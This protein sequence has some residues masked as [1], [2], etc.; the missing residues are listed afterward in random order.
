MTELPPTPL[1]QPALHESGLRH[2][3]GQARY[4][5]DLPAPLVAHVLTSPLPRGRIVRLDVTAARAV[6]GV[7]A[8]L[9]ARD[10]P[11]KNDI[12]PIFHDEPLL[13]E[14]EVFAV[15]QAIVLVVGD[16][17]AACRAGA[18]AVVLELES[19]S[20]Q[21]PSEVQAKVAEVLGLGRHKVTV[22]VP[23]WAAAS[24]ARRPRARTTPPWRRWR[25]ARHG[26]PVKVWLNR[27][28]DMQ[29]TGK[30]HPFLARYEAGFDATGQLLGAARGE[31]RR[32]RLEPRP[33][34]RHPRCAPVPP[35]QRLLTCR[36]A[37]VGR[38]AKTARPPRP[39]PRF[40]AS[41]ARRACGHRG[42]H[43]SRAAELDLPA[44]GA[45]AQLLR[46]GPARRD[47]VPP[48]R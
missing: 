10:I 37:L 45:R 36:R 15:G 21:H 41:A 29:L 32:R 2:T 31:L 24:A 22:E 26:R 4:V 16:S 13:A 38:I 48:G 1:Y 27:D 44:R 33:V 12:A 42:H 7:R 8:V 47:A 18:R 46:R 6:P 40:A 23:R 35:R 43:G 3:T 30:R 9:T 39:T 25:R 17:Y 14:S 11:G 28:Q 34:A 5:D 19:S 20:T